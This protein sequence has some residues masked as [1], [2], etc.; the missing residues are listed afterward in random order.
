MQRRRQQE[1]QRWK[2]SQ[3]LRATK[4]SLRIGTIKTR[5]G[6][7]DAETQAAGGAE[8]E[9]EPRLAGNQDESQNRDDQDQSGTERC[10]DAGSRRCRDGNGAKACGQPRRVSES[11][12]SRPEWDREMQRRRQQEV[13]RWKWSQGLR[14]TKT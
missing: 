8:M 1:V 12:R 4:T 10:R 14:A 13:Q 11:G 5:V 6:Q 3:G 7:R 9:M 2:W